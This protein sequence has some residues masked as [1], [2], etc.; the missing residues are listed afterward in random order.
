MTTTQI[1]H[2]QKVR[3]PLVL[4][5]NPRK[6]SD[7]D[8]YSSILCL[9]CKKGTHNNTIVFYTDHIVNKKCTAEFFKY[10]SEYTTAL[11]LRKAT[12]VLTKPEEKMLEVQTT[13]DS[14]EMRRRIA[15]LEAKLAEAEGEIKDLQEANNDYSNEV[16]T[17]KKKSNDN[18]NLILLV[19]KYMNCPKSISEIHTLKLMDGEAIQLLERY[20][21]SDVGN[22]ED[23]ITTEEDEIEPEANKIIPTAIPTPTASV[24]KTINKTV[25]N[26]ELI[27][28][29]MLALGTI[30]EEDMP[31]KL[32]RCEYEELV[33]E[34]EP[35]NLGKPY[36]LL[37]DF[38]RDDCTV[39]D[40]EEYLHSLLN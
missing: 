4:V 3:I 11:E 13:N 38:I 9:G 7:K 30:V 21:E 5:N 20:N 33:E 34:L 27:K 36:D 40:L 17:L 23:S 10:E 18:D 1:E 15:E 2:I 24:P 39:S 12:E 31:Y 14:V 16:Q 22:T 35:Y 29:V 37:R 8:C 25:G 26:P 6:T 19:E 28:R 32:A